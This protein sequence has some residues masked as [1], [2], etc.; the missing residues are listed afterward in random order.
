MTTADAALPAISTLTA[1]GLLDSQ[2]Y[3]LKVGS[4]A[5]GPWMWTQNW[6]FTCPSLR[7]PPAPSRTL[8]LL[9]D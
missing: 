4:G 6:G 7:S 3:F 1:V 9:L 2:E 8:D 5:G